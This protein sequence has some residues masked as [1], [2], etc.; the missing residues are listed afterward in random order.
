MTSLKGVRNQLLIIHDEG[1]LNDDEL[2]L[3]YDLNGSRSFRPMSCSPGVVSPG[4]RV[5]SP[6]V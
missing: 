4:P 3:L 5:D 2:L 1:V 6:G